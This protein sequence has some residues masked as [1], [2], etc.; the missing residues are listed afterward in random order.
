MVRPVHTL[1]GQLNVHVITWTWCVN[2]SL[3][4]LPSL[5][6]A[7]V[8]HE[9]KGKWQRLGDK[10][11]QNHGVVCPM[12]RVMRNTVWK[13]KTFHQFNRDNIVQEQK[14]NLNLN[15]WFMGYKKQCTTV[16]E[17]TL[18][19]W[20]FYDW[21]LVMQLFNGSVE[22]SGF[23]PHTWRLLLEQICCWHNNFLLWNQYQYQSI[24][25][26]FLFFFLPNVVPLISILLI[27]WITHK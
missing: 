17:S 5:V 15:T 11:Q 9:A 24:L 22:G 25:F 10:E 6:D 3:L 13:Y 20:R 16:A 8:L 7:N 12:T 14:I 19:I 2:V 26:S 27:I 4:C 18:A 1:E 21:D 23:E